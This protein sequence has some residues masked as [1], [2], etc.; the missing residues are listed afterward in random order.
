MSMGDVLALTS[1]VDVS[2]YE[3]DPKSRSILGV[4]SNRLCRLLSICRGG[5]LV[6]MVRFLGL[7]SVRDSVEVFNVSLRDSSEASLIIGRQ[8]CRGV[9]N[10]RDFE[11]ISD[12]GEGSGR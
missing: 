7:F 8:L 9:L 5:V 6:E 1:G 4:R 10:K 3:W 11:G 12:D 2:E